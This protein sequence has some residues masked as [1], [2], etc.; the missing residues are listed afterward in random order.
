MQSPL[1]PI[2]I[3]L[4]YKLGIYVNVV[5]CPMVYTVWQQGN[6][7]FRIDAIH[8]KYKQ[9]ATPYTTNYILLFRTTGRANYVIP[10]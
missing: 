10:D 1:K 4:E 5:D 9:G 2:Y 8:A 3:N 7:F 6:R